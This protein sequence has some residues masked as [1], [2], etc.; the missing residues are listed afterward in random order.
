MKMCL[1]TGDLVIFIVGLEPAAAFAAPPAWSHPSVHLPSP[2]LPLLPSHP[3]L[4]H[5]E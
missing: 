2:G 3:P 4:I 5:Y 1:S